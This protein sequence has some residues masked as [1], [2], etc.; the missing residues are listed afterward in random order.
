ME[1]KEVIKKRKSIRV[2]QKKEVPDLTKLIALAKTGPSA[3]GIRGFEVV[4]TKEKIIY[5]DAPLYL[6]ICANPEAYAKKYGDRGRNLYS[7]QDATI[8]GA[9]LQLLLV[10]MGLASV[11]IGAFRE[12]RVA[13]TLGTNLRPIAVIAVGYA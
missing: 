1:L 11:W 3:G 10:E 8:C 4:V 5:L 6:V 12:R 7:I 13:R 9:Y 2:F